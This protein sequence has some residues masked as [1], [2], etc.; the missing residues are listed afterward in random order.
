M[1]AVFCLN[2]SYSGI[3]DHS[4]ALYA[5]LLD[6]ESTAD[7]ARDSGTYGIRLTGNPL[8]LNY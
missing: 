7:A 6:T 5:Y 2:T 4:I 1:V 8:M 3:E